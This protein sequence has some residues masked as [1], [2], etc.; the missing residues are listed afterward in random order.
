MARKLQLDVDLNTT[1]ECDLDDLLE[2]V[3]EPDDTLDDLIERY[4]DDTL[5][6]EEFSL[7]AGRAWATGVSRW[8]IIGGRF[9]T[10][11]GPRRP[12]GFSKTTVE[13]AVRSRHREWYGVER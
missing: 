6:G 8:S 7:T 10:K 13:R 12:I 2:Y 3:E 4:L 5:G 9:W 11:G 1:A